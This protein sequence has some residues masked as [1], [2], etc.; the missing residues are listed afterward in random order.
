[1]N[2]VIEKKSS[3]Q[4]GI[5]TDSDEQSMQRK[6]AMDDNEDYATSR[7]A[8]STENQDA[9]PSEASQSTDSSGAHHE[10]DEGGMIYRL[11]TNNHCLWRCCKSFPRTTALCYGVVFPL[12]V[13]C[14]M[15][16]VF[17]LL[18]AR[19]EAPNEVRENDRILGETAEEIAAAESLGAMISRI[20]QTCLHLFFVNETNSNDTLSGMILKEIRQNETQ[21]EQA[22]SLTSVGQVV[23]VNTTELSS[24]MEQCG[25]AAGPHLQILVDGLVNATV[26]TSDLTFN[27][28]R[29]FPGAKGISSLEIPW[30]TR[31]NLYEIQFQAQQELYVQVW[32]ADQ[33]RLQQEFMKLLISRKDD[34]LDDTQRI[35]QSF[36]QSIAQ[37]T[38]GTICDLNGAASG[39]F[40][41][42]LL[43]TVGYGNQSITTTL[44]RRYAYGFGLMSILAFGVMLSTAGYVLSCV[45][46][47][48][49][50]RYRLHFFTNKW[51]S[52]I[53]WGILYTTSMVC[54][55]ALTVRWKKERLNLQEFSFTDGFWFAYISSTTIGLG[56]IFL[57]PEVFLGADLMT[58]PLL[59]LF[60]FV[61]AS[62]FIAKFCRIIASVVGKRS[63]LE[64]LL[65]ELKVV[66]PM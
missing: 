42:I 63:L 3:V 21:R 66:N 57:E 14:I 35:L 1:M 27:W 16:T 46:D 22:F 18:L 61:L 39:W 29:C 5:S 23:E 6:G 20:P 30:L 34:V 56:D 40:W 32:K 59:F 12:A 62:A 4:Y 60:S 53:L 9:K 48:A 43:A 17:G 65:S 45:V 7:T 31:E 13:L 15:S 50:V 24:F 8:Q 11:I 33:K 36:K 28:I 44:G 25:Q 10:T 19:A 64:D 2:K 51:A 58:F 26:A 37:A 47:D 38:G 54:I 55:A 52:C 41:F 49:L